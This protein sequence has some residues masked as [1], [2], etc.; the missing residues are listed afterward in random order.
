MQ[1]LKN[2]MSLFSIR[3]MTGSAIYFGYLVKKSAH[4]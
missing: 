2:G 3:K 4:R 1:D